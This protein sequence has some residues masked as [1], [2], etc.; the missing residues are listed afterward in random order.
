MRRTHWHR[1]DSRTW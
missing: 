1:T